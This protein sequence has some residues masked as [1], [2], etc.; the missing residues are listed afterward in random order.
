M[1]VIYIKCLHKN[2]YFKKAH[3]RI[4]IFINIIYI[5]YSH[6]MYGHAVMNYNLNINYIKPKNYFF[7]MIYEY[8]IGIGNGF[9]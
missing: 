1:Y 4:N 7:Y 2:Q 5:K 6:V 8:D 9:K 3:T